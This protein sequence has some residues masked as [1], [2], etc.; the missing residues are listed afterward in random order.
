MADQRAMAFVNLYGVL[1]AL[2]HLCALDAQAKSVLQRL[3]QPV[4]LCFEV[5]NGPCGTLHFDRDGCIFTEG[6]QGCT[7]KMSF[8]HRP[9]LTI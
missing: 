9:P 3:K 6:S 8:P 2:E 4:S 1:A 7:C 5:K